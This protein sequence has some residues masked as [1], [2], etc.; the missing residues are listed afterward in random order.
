MNLKKSRTRIVSW[1]DSALLFLT[2]LFL[3]TQ[4]GKHFWPPF[5]YIYSLKVDY[6]SPTVYFWDLL[7]L[8]LIGIF[9]GKGVFNKKAIFLFFIFLLSQI[10]SL[11]LASNIGA[12]FIRFEQ[13]FTAG[14]LGVYLASQ[15][16]IRIK[17][18]LCLALTLG[19]V[20]EGGLA[21]C[22]FLL[23][24]SLGFWILGERSFSMSTPSIANF[25][26]YGQIFLR[27]YGTFP[28]PN[29][30]SAFMILV[31]PIV[32]FFNKNIIILILG[33]VSI[34]LSFSRSAILILFGMAFHYFKNLKVLFIILVLLLPILLVRFSSALNFDNLSIIRREELSRI[35]VSQISKSPLIG[36][37]LNNFISGV[38]E[39]D[40]VA[41]PS[42]FLQPVHNI[43]LLNLSETGVVGLVGLFVLIAYPIL[44][45]WIK[46][47]EPFARLLLLS[48]FSILFLGLFDHYFLTLPQGQR[49]LFLIWGLSMLEY[50][51]WK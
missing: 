5:S 14:L 44:R 31:L 3:P 37:G 43:F 26:F 50:S 34:I 36:V 21:I 33:S 18:V 23:G 39:S 27:P 41:G 9:F 11:L 42:R 47:K 48:W 30:L 6:L 7:I 8:A 19:L 12:G 1:L 2:I 22:Q 15:K 32:T 16:L 28:H 49:L 13:Y 38:A 46:R 51:K 17:K 35:A 24:K 25:N 40:L 29:V 45:L 10:V 20:F 4:L